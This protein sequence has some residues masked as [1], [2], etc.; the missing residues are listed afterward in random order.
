VLVNNW[1]IIMNVISM[2]Q[3]KKQAFSTS[4]KVCFILPQKYR[5]LFICKN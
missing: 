3:A 4:K 1:G 5:T 2:H